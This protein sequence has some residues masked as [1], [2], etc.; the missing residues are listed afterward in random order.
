MDKIHTGSHTGDFQKVHY[1]DLYIATIIHRD[2]G[3]PGPH[4][5][6]FGAIPVVHPG[7]FFKQNQRKMVFARVFAWFR[8]GFPA[9][10]AWFSHG[11][12]FKGGTLLP[13]KPF[14]IF[15]HGYSLQRGD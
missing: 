5:G 8:V 12:L 11:Y 15:S 1:M 2:E 3:Y 14:R 10:F 13:R 4:P 6:G 7:G 9:D